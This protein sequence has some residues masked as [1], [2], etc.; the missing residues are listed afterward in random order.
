MRGGG[1]RPVPVGLAEKQG[2]LARQADFGVPLP[3]RQGRADL[4]RQGCA[5]QYIAILAM[6][7]AIAYPD[8]LMNAALR[9]LP[10]STA[11]G[12]LTEPISRS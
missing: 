12:R 9:V 3:R 11:A 7:Y 1:G 2:Y 8:E 4:K 6:A 10:P 5:V